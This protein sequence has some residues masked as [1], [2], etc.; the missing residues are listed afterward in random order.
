M[1]QIEAERQRRGWSM[2]EMAR[3]ANVAPSSYRRFAAGRIR[4]ADAVVHYADALGGRMVW[5]PYP[6][7]DDFEG[8][9]DVEAT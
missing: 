1:R 8:E 2:E 3:R 7:D 9:A 6:L 4:T 5:E